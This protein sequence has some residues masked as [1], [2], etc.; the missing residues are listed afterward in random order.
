MTMCKTDYGGE[1]GKNVPKIDYVVCELHIAM[2]QRVL[3]DALLSQVDRLRRSRA[4]ASE[5]AYMVRAIWKRPF[6]RIQ[7]SRPY[8]QSRYQYLALNNN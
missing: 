2:C 5:M 7:I 8:Y 6:E 1:G 4:T 3:R